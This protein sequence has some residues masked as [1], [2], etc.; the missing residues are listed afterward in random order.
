LGFW[1]FK[2]WLWALSFFTPLGPFKFGKI[3]GIFPKVF[4]QL[5]GGPLGTPFR[6]ALKIWSQKEPFVGIFGE[7]P[8][9]GGAFGF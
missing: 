9:F 4:G 1:G 2:R 6:G 5:L 3:W 7:F 8:H